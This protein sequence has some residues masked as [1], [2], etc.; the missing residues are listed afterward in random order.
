MASVTLYEYDGEEMGPGGSR[1]RWVEFLELEYDSSEESYEEAL[2]AVLPNLQRVTFKGGWAV[3]KRR[4]AFEVD[5]DG[6]PLY[7]A[8]VE[9]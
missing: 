2:E 1:P 4:K 7:R 6:R 5:V 8:E 9:E 3:N